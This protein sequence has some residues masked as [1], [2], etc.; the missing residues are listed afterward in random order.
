MEAAWALGK[1]G[2]VPQSD[3]QRAEY[4]I[5]GEQWKELVR[6][7]GPAIPPL[8][9]ALGGIGYS[10]V[11]TG[12]SEALRQLGGQPAL[13]ALKME[14]ALKDP[15]RRQRALA[16]L[17]YIRQRQEEVS[18]TKPAQEDAS[19]YKEELKEGGLAIQKR[20]EKQFGAELRPRTNGSKNPRRRP[21]TR[22]KTSPSSP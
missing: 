1:L 8:I 2:W 14:A 18:R 9:R 5:A 15:E 13:S 6:M 21:A 7:G 22:C 10:G 20:F 12:A 19:R 11:R 16:A 17:E 4:L 3:L